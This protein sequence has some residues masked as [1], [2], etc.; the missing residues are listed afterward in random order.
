MPMNKELVGRS[1]P[2]TFTFETVDPRKSPVVSQ[3]LAE[4]RPEAS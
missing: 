4:I 1:Y 2:D 3:G